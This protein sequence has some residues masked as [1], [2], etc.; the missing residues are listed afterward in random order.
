MSR[1]TKILALSLLSFVLSY[2]TA[3]ASPFTL[4]P[5]GTTEAN[6]LVSYAASHSWDNN[7]YN[8]IFTSFSSVTGGWASLANINPFKLTADA[9]TL[10]FQL[11]YEGAALAGINHL[12]LSVDGS[13]YTNI[14]TG[15]ASAG[16][17]TSV[18]LNDSSTYSFVLDST[19]NNYVDNNLNDNRSIFTSGDN[20]FDLTTHIVALQILVDGIVNI[21]GRSFSVLVGDIIL[22]GEDLGDVASSSRIDTDYDYNDMVIRVRGG[23]SSAIPEPT[24]MLLFGSSL[25]GL[26]ALRKSKK[27]L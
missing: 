21:A 3:I 22:F 20:N 19:D 6:S 11:M 2:Q 7:A 18:T 23:G 16:S 25:I 17:S 15:S 26:G 4:S 24:T 1:S 5:L 27:S 8:N 9:T 13:S 10:D 12:G 14:F